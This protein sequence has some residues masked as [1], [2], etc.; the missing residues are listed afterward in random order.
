MQIFGI[1]WWVWLLFL[2]LVG[3][4]Q[5]SSSSNQASESKRSEDAASI[6]ERDDVKSAIKSGKFETIDL[7]SGEGPAIEE[8]KT[9]VMHYT[10]WLT[11]GSKFDSSRDRDET[12]PFRLGAG[13]VIAGWEQ[14]VK[15][16][17]AGG[18]RILII[19]PDLGY[20]ARSVGQGLIPANSTLVFEVELVRID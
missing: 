14:G 3:C 13:Q 4:D 8:G 18:K 10:G 5:C 17:K 12:F 16:M 9:A 19:P 6:L 2:G 15:G 1:K 7:V 20:G 11:T